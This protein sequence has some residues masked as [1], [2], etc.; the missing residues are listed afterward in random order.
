MS[1]LPRV[2]PASV[3]YSKL[4]PLGVKAQSKMRKF[5]PNN[6]SVFNATSN[7]IRIPLNTTGFLDA[8]HSALSFTCTFTKS[9]FGAITCS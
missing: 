3:D 4:L 5:Q 7:I 2:P 6:G 8:Q 9:S 1:N